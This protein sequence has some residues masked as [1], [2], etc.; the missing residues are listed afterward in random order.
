MIQKKITALGQADS[1]ALETLYKATVRATQ[2]FAAVQA[3]I[4]SGGS[5][6]RLGEGLWVVSRDTSDPEPTPGA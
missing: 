2:A 1:D 4:A 3:R 6:Q 5:I